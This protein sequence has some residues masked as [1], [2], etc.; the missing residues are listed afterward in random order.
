MKKKGVTVII[1]VITG[2]CV[3]INM[4]VY[5][6][7][8][9]EWTENYIFRCKDFWQYNSEIQ[10]YS[11]EKV[12]LLDTME[13]WKEPLLFLI[14][15]NFIRIANLSASDGHI[16]IAALIQFL[17]ILWI[18]I[19]I[20]RETKSNIIWWSTSLIFGLSYVSNIALDSLF[21]RQALSNLFIL[22]LIA[23][24]SII[25]LWK[26]SIQKCI[27]L[28][29]ILAWCFIS[30]KI[31][32]VFSILWLTSLMIYYSLKGWGR[33]NHDLFIVLFC[34][35]VVAGPILYIFVTSFLTYFHEYMI[36]Y[37]N[38]KSGE[39]EIIWKFS[40]NLSEWVS[41]LPVNKNWTSAFIN[42]FYS[43]SFLIFLLISRIRLIFLK[44]YRESPHTL[45]FLL[46]GISYTSVQIAF[47]NRVIIFTN[48]MIIIYIWLLFKS[49][50]N[51]K[52]SRILW[53]ILIIILWTITLSPKTITWSTHLTHRRINI[54][55]DGSVAFIKE[56]ISP[57][58]SFF[59]WNHCL[60]EFIAQ[61]GYKSSLNFWNLTIWKEKEKRKMGESTFEELGGRSDVMASTL[62]AN[63]FV[64]S[65]L[66]NKDIYIIIWPYFGVKHQN[67]IKKFRKYPNL[68]LNEYI[69]LIY[70]NPDPTWYVTYIFKVD[71]TKLTYFDDINYFDRTMNNII[72]PI[73]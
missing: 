14:I 70:S 30:H 39:Q 2:L 41:I 31:A 53:I 43:Q 69:E 40:V 34:T 23:S 56:R 10:E 35:I 54:K 26:L 27:F 4:F 5:F 51:N 64:I 68:F 13:V 67:L 6:G 62:F 55:N 32:F 3:V 21:T 12:K 60:N 71:K 11:K 8:L 50:F 24:L 29:I 59:V 44:I 15:S 48:I 16:L 25:K 42:Y 18:H 45:I 65:P 1:L 63:K 17:T 72:S 49:I 33:K 7:V 19:T 20:R 37:M 61:I 52:L 73:D 28:S 58:K 22:L 36:K 9:S 46:I 47:T 38:I 66:K 57:E